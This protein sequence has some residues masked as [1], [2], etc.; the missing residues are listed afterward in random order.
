MS[1]L[2]ESTEQFYDDSDL[3]ALVKNNEI[4]EYPVYYSSIVNRAHPVSMYT[5][6]Q[7]ENKPITPPYHYVPEKLTV[8]DDGSVVL[9][10]GNVVPIPLNTLLQRATGPLLIRGI[11]ETLEIPAALSDHIFSLLEKNTEE[12]LDNFA[13]EKGYKNIETAISYV[14][15]NNQQFSDEGKY[16]L[17]IRDTVWATFFAQKNDITSKKIPYP[18]SWESFRTHLPELVWPNI[19]E[20]VVTIPVAPPEVATDPIE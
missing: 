2:S 9:K 8:Q 5:K 1:D 7:F 4:V 14:G 16:C 6:V 15:S 13:K 3:F 12:L 20:P 18:E 17:S 19:D 10:Y 11:A